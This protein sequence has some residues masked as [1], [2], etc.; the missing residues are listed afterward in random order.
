MRRAAPAAAALL[1]L[2]CARASP[3]ERLLR[4]AGRGDPGSVAA[5]LAGGASPNATSES[6]WTPLMH[7]AAHGDAESVQLL[8]ASG[9]DVAAATPREGQQPL[10]LAARWNRVGVVRTLLKTADPGRRDRIGWTALLWAAHLGRTDVV[11]A[12]LD[13]GADPNTRDTDKN[14]PLINAARRGRV[15]TVKLLLARGARTQDRTEEGETAA[16]LAARGGHP[17]LAALLKVR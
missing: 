14:T 10:I 15:E 11:A 17:D 3:D 12:L 6:G 7:A 9:A 13:G 2:A 16:S 5:L 4:A 8:V 1:A